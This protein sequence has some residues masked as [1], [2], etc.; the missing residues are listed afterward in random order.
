M[1][2]GRRLAVVCVTLSA[3]HDRGV[4]DN[5]SDKEN[6]SREVLVCEGN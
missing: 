6:Y 5:W 3:P 4:Q 1:G 2:D